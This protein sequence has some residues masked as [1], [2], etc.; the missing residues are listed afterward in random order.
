MDYPLPTVA[1]LSSHIKALRKARGLTQA[2]LGQ[3][4]GVKQSRIAD[5]EKNPGAIG[6]A[7]MHQVLSALGAQLWLRD[8][9]AGWSPFQSS[10]AA[11]EQR[12]AQTQ[13]Q[14]K[15]RGA[16]PKSP[17]LGKTLKPPAAVKV[18]PDARTSKGGK[19]PGGVW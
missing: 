13:T 10:G 5:I 6:F 3:L 9:G 18:G 14:P 16:S 1:Q 8:T 12:V 15:P 11:P 19:K 2:A 4:L 17:A 7:Q